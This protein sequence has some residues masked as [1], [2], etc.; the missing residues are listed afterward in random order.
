MAILWDEVRVAKLEKLVM[1]MK[2]GLE[3]LSQMQTHSSAM[4][5]QEVE[6]LQEQ[7]DTLK[8]WNLSVGEL[9]SSFANRS[10]DNEK[11]CLSKNE[12]VSGSE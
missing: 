8:S 5:K 12:I 1:E 10:E 9:F 2:G 3:R 11:D 6:S 7:I 4:K